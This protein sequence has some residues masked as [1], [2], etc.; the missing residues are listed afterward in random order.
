MAV[1]G[2]DDVMR[3]FDEQARRISG[4]LS[5]RFV[6]EVLITVAGYAAY[7]T[8][9]DTSN[10][11]NSQFRRVKKTTNGYEGELGY[12][13]SYAPFVHDGPQKNWQKSSA[14]NKFLEKGVEEMIK[15]DL[16]NLIDRN[17]D[18]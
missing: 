9:V 4:P 10:L 5:N 6:T 1:E 16:E 12:G 8:P 14:S 18:V 17:F 15:T 7:Y 11:I 2:E 3:Y 13:A